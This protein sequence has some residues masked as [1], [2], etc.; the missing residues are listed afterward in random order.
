MKLLFII[1]FIFAPATAILL[2]SSS[3]RSF[4]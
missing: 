1:L 2:F 3:T 4:L